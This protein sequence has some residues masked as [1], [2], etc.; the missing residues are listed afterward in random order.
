MLAWTALVAGNAEE[1]R[2]QVLLAR[3]SNPNSP[4][5]ILIEAHI[6]VHTGQ[7]VQA[8]QGLAAFLRVDPRGPYSGM[9]M[10]WF[11][12]SY[13]YERDYARSVEASRRFVARYR[14]FRTAIG[15]SRRR[16]ASWVEQKKHRSR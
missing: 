1:A 3:G 16:W 8:R 7:P 4:L 11:A 13:Y 14:M 2:D 9:A 15:G 10:H 6:L 12:I 5:A